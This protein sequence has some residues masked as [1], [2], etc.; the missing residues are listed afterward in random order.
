MIVRSVSEEAT[1]MSGRLMD[2]RQLLLVRTAVRAAQAYRQGAVID[3]DGLGRWLHD[4]SLGSNGLR[5]QASVSFSTDGF[6]DVTGAGDTYVYQ[7]RFAEPFDDLTARLALA[8]LPGSGNLTY[9]YALSALLLAAASFGLL[10]IYRMVAVV[11]AFAERRSNFVAA[12]SHELKTPLTAIR[13]YAEMLRDGIVPSETK[14]GEYYRHITAESE[15]LSRLIDNVLEFSRLEKGNRT[16]NLV[17]ASVVP[18]VREAAELLR[19]HVEGAG[20]RLLV[21]CDEHVPPVRFERDAL[22]QVLCNLGDNAVKYA[23]DSTPRDIELRCQHDNG[24]VVLTVRDHGP[25]VP[26]RHLGKIFEPF[27]R[28]ENELTR[29][30]KGTGLGLALVRSLCE[31]M[32]AEVNGRN[33]ATGGFEVEIRLHT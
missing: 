29:R 7:H 15:R 11:V 23:V 30:T 33:V 3:L 22:V 27:Y 6:P 21:E 18:V 32:G 17:S 14:R 25:G 24:A 2:P 31:R 20:F 9:I 10:A 4:S 26:Q 5:E 19:S 16:I 12:V 8:S 1:P 13:M 28:G